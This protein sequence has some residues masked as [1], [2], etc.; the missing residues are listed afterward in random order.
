V[1]SQPGLTAWQWLPVTP[2]FARRRHAAFFEEEFGMCFAS[3]STVH[4]QHGSSRSGTGHAAAGRRAGYRYIGPAVLVGAACLALAGCGGGYSN[5][6]NSGGSTPTPTPT[7]SPTVSAA[8]TETV[9]GTIQDAYSNNGGLANATVT[10]DGQSATTNAAGTF[11]VTLTGAQS[12]ITLTIAAPS[13][14]AGLAPYIYFSASQACV[15]PGSL[16]AP[17][18]TTTVAGSIAAGQNVSLG[19][20]TVYNVSN[21]GQQPPYTPC[22]P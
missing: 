16:P 11:S 7:P 5:S 19:T 3:E 22:I 17:T 15:D 21:Q 18:I 12:G 8:V 9:T 6:N 20:I 14:S 4:G 2:A 1:I 10:I 13:G